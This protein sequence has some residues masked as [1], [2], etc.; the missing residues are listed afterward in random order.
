MHLSYCYKIILNIIGALRFSSLETK[1]IIY[2]M[3][4]ISA[5]GTAKICKSFL[6]FLYFE[7]SFDF[8]CL[9]F[10]SLTNCLL[11]NDIFCEAKS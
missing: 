11:S 10:E 6:Q 5:S 8:A 7:I 4:S 2:K 9:Q 1:I 3:E